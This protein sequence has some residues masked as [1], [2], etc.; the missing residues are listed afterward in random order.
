MTT[1]TVTV[2]MIPMESHFSRTMV[3]PIIDAALIRLFCSH[4]FHLLLTF[5]QSLMDS[6]DFRFFSLFIQYPHI[7]VRRQDDLSP[8]FDRIFSSSPKPRPVKS[9]YCGFSA[10][11]LSSWLLHCSHLLV[12]PDHLVELPEQV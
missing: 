7:S 1:A 12:H 9:A 5:P 4:D 6:R 2:R 3:F 8:H 10:I 11:N